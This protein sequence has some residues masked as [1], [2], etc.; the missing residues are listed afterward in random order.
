MTTNAEGTGSGVEAVCVSRT[1]RWRSSVSFWSAI[2]VPFEDERA[3]L[4]CNKHN[5]H[6]P[7]RRGL[8]GTRQHREGVIGPANWHSTYLQRPTHRNVATGQL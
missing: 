5:S 4:A 2:S 7:E 3:R 8:G 6:D 1:P